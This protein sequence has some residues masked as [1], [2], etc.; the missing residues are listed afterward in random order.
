VSTKARHGDH[1]AA[2]PD[3][4]IRRLDTR[5]DRDNRTVAHMHVACREITEARIHGQHGGATDDKLA[6]RW[7]RGCR[8]RA[9]LGEKLPRSGQ[10]RAERRRSLQHRAPAH[11][12]V[13]HLHP[14]R[15]CC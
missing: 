6:A 4:H 14:P 1:A 2:V 10:E 8:P 3:Y 13:C 12:M 11:M 9:L 5:P 7:Q 15:L